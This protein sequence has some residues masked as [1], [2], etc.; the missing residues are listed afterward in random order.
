MTFNTKTS[1]R[2]P[3]S[4]VALIND[5]CDGS[6]SDLNVTELCPR[7]KKIEPTP[8]IDTSMTCLLSAQLALR[9]PSWYIGRV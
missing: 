3:C 7:Y 6:L 5:S 4:I 8:Y 9:E 1:Q 2:L